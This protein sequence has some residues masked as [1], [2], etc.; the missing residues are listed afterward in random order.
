LK[1]DVVHARP[2]TPPCHQGR[3]DRMFKFR[4][5]LIAVAADEVLANG[6]GQI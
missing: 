4:T 5:Y 6:E 1:H 3:E 2:V